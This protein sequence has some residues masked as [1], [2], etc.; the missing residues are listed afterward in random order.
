MRR[1][2]SLLVLTA[3]CADFSEE[4]LIGEYACRSHQDCAGGQLCNVVLGRCV[5]PPPGAA[6]D[7]CDVVPCDEANGLVCVPAAQ[8]PSGGAVCRAACSNGT[9]S[10]P[11]T[12]CAPLDPSPACVPKQGVGDDCS[13][14]ECQPALQCVRGEPG[15]PDSL[16]C[17]PVCDATTSS[18]SCR[19]SELCAALT[20][21]GAACVIDPCAAI[22]CGAGAACE[23]TSAIEAKCTAAGLAQGTFSAPLS[24]FSAAV[25]GQASGQIA[26]PSVAQYAPSVAFATVVE[27]Q[28]VSYLLVEIDTPNQG[29]NYTSLL[30]ATP[31]RDI[32]LGR[33]IAIGWTALA[34]L[35]TVSGGTATTRASGVSGTVTFSSASLTIGGQVTGAFD[36]ALI[37]EP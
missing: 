10:D 20:A 35:D 19:T 28:G 31:S 15:S 37:A 4:V 29:G 13:A 12:R 21:G 6:G 32:P 7:A 27:L 36:F 25:P 18:P 22:A 8:D 5:A 34:R 9:C 26:A 24:D 2:A 3:A 14:L 30:I 11:A 16:R 17:R 33:A 23:R 1:V